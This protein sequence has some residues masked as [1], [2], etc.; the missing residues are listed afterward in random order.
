M[1]ENGTQRLAQTSA[2]L[3]DTQAS[4]A[5]TALAST[6]LLMRAAAFS[7]TTLPQDTLLQIIPLLL[8]QLQPVMTDL[9]ETTTTEH[10]IHVTLQLP[11][12]RLHATLQ[13]R[14][15]MR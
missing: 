7:T 5:L 1:I 11:P 10:L 8:T 4:N 12:L 2:G 14:D 9:P 15:G 13:A 3:N 6:F